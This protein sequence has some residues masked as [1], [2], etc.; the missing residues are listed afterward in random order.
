[1]NKNGKKVILSEM[2][3]DRGNVRLGVEGVEW[4]EGGGRGRKG[5]ERRR[6]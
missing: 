1:M 6:N 3:S 2:E 5:K 4:R